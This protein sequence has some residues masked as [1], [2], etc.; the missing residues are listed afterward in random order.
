MNRS[1]RSLLALAA[2]ALP[3]T[4]GGCVIVNADSHT[5][6]EGRYVG[7][8]TLA[9][10]RPG[11]TQEYVLALVGEPSSRNELSDGSAVWKWTYSQRVTSKNHVLLLF[12]GDSSRVTQGAVY[13]EFGP[14][15]LV[16][17]TWR[18]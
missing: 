11:A 8:E 12:S 13:V 2:L 15:K 3:T 5:S 9:Q 7:D 1:T 16:R 17:R 4:L 14:D 6:H 18:D 10:I